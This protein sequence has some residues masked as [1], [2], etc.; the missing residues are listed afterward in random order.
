VHGSTENMCESKTVPTV[1]DVVRT[2]SKEQDGPSIDVFTETSVD[3]ANMAQSEESRNQDLPPLRKFIQNLRDCI[4]T[5]DYQSLGTKESRAYVEACGDHVRYHGIDARVLLNFNYR[6]TYARDDFATM[7]DNLRAV[8]YSYYGL[9]ALEK[10]TDTTARREMWCMANLL[11]TSFVSLFTSG[12]AP[13]ETFT[14]PYARYP[15]LIAKQ[16][17]ATD[18][19]I[20]KIICESLLEEIDEEA[21]QMSS[22][23]AK[24][25]RLIQNLPVLHRYAPVENPF[26][27]QRKSRLYSKLPQSTVEEDGGDLVEQVRQTVQFLNVKQKKID[28]LPRL[29]QSWKEEGIPDNKIK[30]VL[31]PLLIGIE[32]SSSNIYLMDLYTALRMLRSYRRERAMGRTGSSYFSRRPEEVETAIVYVGDHHRRVYRKMLFRVGFRETANIDKESRRFDDEPSRCLHLPSS[33]GALLVPD[34]PAEDVSVVSAESGPVKTSRSASFKS[35]RSSSRSASF[36]SAR[37]RSSS[38]I[39]K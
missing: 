39:R 11:P 24:C 37:S 27:K 36:K 13:D 12:R 7:E 28:E 31:L 21:K 15:A 32:K 4:A 23:I 17:R 18:P 22:T 20:V 29:I 5:T 19:E 30:N 8:Q 10:E 3:I 9:A 26:Q 14:G 35:A 38:S 2:L 25:Q 33:I 6:Y 16:V 1:L 34:V